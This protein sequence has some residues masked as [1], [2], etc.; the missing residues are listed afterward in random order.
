MAHLYHIRPWEWPLLDYGTTLNLCRA[1]D[2]ERQE[3]KGTT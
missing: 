1:I 2:R 3:Q